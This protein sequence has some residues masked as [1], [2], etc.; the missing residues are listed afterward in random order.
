[1][2]WV[3]L[4]LGFATVVALARG[5]HL[6]NF[7]D[8]RLRLWWLLPLGFA[9]Q[10][11]TEFFPSGASWSHPVG[12]GLVL[13]SYGPLLA[14]AALNRDMPGMWLVGVGVL[15]N[16]TVIAA[17]SGM[18]VLTEAALVAGG[19]N[20]SVTLV[21]DFKHVV[22]GPTSNLTFLGDV[23]PLRI[24][25]QGQVISLGDVFLA[26]GLARF[27]EFQLRKPVRWFKHGVHSAAGSAAQR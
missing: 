13:A 4:V 25:G 3:A 2:V 14:L 1:M 19:F 18:P 10:A 7:T 12:V 27:L 6:A 15:M 20:D 24:F 21:T 23:I 9:M 22:M 26:V 17:N 16:F 5:G 8:I 11:V